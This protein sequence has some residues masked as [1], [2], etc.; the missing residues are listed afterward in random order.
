VICIVVI[1]V[2]SAIVPTGLMPSGWSAQSQERGGSES[3]LRTV[4]RGRSRSPHRSSQSGIQC[5]PPPAEHASAKYQSSCL[6]CRV[7]P[8]VDR[9][10]LAV[11]RA[12]E[13]VPAVRVGVVSRDLAARLMALAQVQPTPEQ[14]QSLCI[15]IAGAQEAVPRTGP[16]TVGSATAPKSLR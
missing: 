10:E 3:L 11:A 13:V 2:H 4:G 7:A 8:E 1:Y 14:S 9:R 16:V 12:Q 6:H 5:T 15:P